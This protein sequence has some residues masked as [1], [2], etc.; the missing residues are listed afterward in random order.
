[1]IQSIFIVLILLLLVCQMLATDEDRVLPGIKAG[2]E[3][4]LP[5]RKTVETERAA[6]R[7]MEAVNPFP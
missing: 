6:E 5:G 7:I 1:M 2:E 3:A 4:S